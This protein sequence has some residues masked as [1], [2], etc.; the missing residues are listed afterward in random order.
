MSDKEKFYTHKQ[1]D[2]ETLDEYFDRVIDETFLTENEV[3]VD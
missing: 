1:R 3:K 2:D